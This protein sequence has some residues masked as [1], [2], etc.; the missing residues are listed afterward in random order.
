MNL[1]LRRAS[2]EVGPINPSKCAHAY[3]DGII[4]SGLCLF[5]VS[6]YE[7]VFSISRN[8]SVYFGQGCPLAAHAV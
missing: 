8:S 1:F 5:F 6:F 3:M 4:K 2:R 7:E